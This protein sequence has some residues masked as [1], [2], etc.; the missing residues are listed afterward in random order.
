MVIRPRLAQ[1]VDDIA[2]ALRQMVGQPPFDAG[3]DLALIEQQINN[4]PAR[5]RSLDPSLPQSLDDVI[6]RSLEKHPDDRYQSANDMAAALEHAAT[7]IG[8]RSA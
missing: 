2:R 4:E 3:D 8:S 6:A 5:V 1:R 7:A